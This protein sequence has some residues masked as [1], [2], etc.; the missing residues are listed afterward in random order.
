MRIIGKRIWLVAAGATTVLG[1][2]QVPALAA[3]NV[4]TPTISISA[5]SGIKPVTGDVFVV[6]RASALANAQIKGTVTGATS[7]QVLQLFAQQFPFKKPAVALGSPVT[8]T[9]TGSSTPYSFKVTPTLATRYRVELFTDSSETTLV[10]TSAVQVVYVTARGHWSGARTCNRRGQ[11]PVCHQR[12]HLTV[13]VPPSTLR[14]ERPKPW[15]LYFGLKLS[16]SGEPSPPKTLKLGAGHAHVVSVKKLNS[17][18]Y[19][20]T[21]TFSFRIGNNGYFFAINACQKDTEPTDG[22]NLPGHHSCG[23]R[24]I[25]SKIPY[26]G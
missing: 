5:K 20:V 11:R 21:M 17:Q 6:F 19:A 1:V 15:H 24:F 14:T 9:P 13:T 23:N 3:P 7:G 4:T 10:A 8:L 25:S 12:V 2:A 22:L 18:Q 26:L 16:R